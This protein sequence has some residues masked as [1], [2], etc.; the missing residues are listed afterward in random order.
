MIHTAPTLANR[1]CRVSSDVASAVVSDLG[2]AS[3]RETS[4]RW[5]VSWYVA[6]FRVFGWFWGGRWG[7]LCWWWAGVRQIG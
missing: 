7:C 4:W 1:E 5:F 2:F 3:W 6:S